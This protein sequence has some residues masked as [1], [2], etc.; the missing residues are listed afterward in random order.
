MRATFYARVS[1]DSEEQK[2][3]IISQV[4]FF[5]EYLQSHKYQPVESGVFCKRD[6]S[7][8]ATQGYYVDEGF[9]GAKSIKY[10][11]A[12][13]Q[14]MR[15]A[16]ARKF[17]IIFTK[18]ISR[19]GRNVQEIL[20]SIGDLKELGI[21][22]YFEDVKINT[23]N[24]SDDLKITIFAGMAQEESRAK[25]DSVQFG[26]MR[27][28]KKGIWGGREPYGYNLK[29]GKLVKNDDEEKIVREVYH[30]FLNE[31][32]GQRNIAKELNARNVPTKS[33]KTIWDQSLVSKML[34]NSV[35]TG[36]IRLHR[37][38]KTDINRNIIKKIPKEEQVVTHDESLRMIDDET[39]RLVQLEKEKRLEK[40][41][42]FKYK[43]II[44]EDEDGNEMNKKQRNIERGLSRHSSKHLFSNLLKCGNC[45]G[46]LRRKVQKN[47]KN[48][49]LYWF[50]R[51]NDQFGKH[52]CGYR[53]LQH[54]EKLIAFVKE[55]IIKYRNTPNKRKYY[56]QTIL[57]TR[58]NAKD[59]EVM[60][61]QLQIEIDEIKIDKKGILK[62]V[63][64]ESITQEEFDELNKEFNVQL[65]E[66]ESK[67]NQLIYIDQEIE[68][69]H[70]RFNQ[71]TAFLNDLDVDNLTNG[72][73]RKIINRIVATTIDEPVFSDDT[74]NF[75]KYTTLEIDW[76]FLDTTE[77]AILTE[78][79]R[80]LRKSMIT[81]PSHELPNEVI[82]QMAEN[83]SREPN[84][85]EI[86]F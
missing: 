67:L 57:K 30:L 41:G 64:R 14:M 12:F 54:E 22:V 39:F 76:N 71:F 74:S 21:G 85:E 78:S 84:E 60:K 17:D 75:D 19:F 16:K 5:Q 29:E 25:S 2:K 28:Y 20:K 82:D 70:L 43:N 45:G 7:V 24:G 36:E 33:G 61:Q 42:D 83:V 35:Y 40:F 11:K 62:Q 34:K 46:S 49:F 27:G 18:N 63:N 55:E 58:Y 38:Q 15:D 52:K 10:R 77:S 50:C 79:F 73:L 59:I 65:Y 32:M 4:D 80:K 26:K 48:T 8:E 9:S 72:V 69:L 81:I 51:N 23:L 68:K 86:L 53:N 66:A 6:G 3:S 31:S 1:S 13:Q 37:T 56:L 47:H 44:V